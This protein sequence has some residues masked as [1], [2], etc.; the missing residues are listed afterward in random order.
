MEKQLSEKDIAKEHVLAQLAARVEANYHAL[1]EGM[2]NVEEVDL[3][4]AQA[5]VQCVG[6]RQRLS[7]AAGGIRDPLLRILH[8]RTRRENLQRVAQVV[9][10]A[11][12]RARVRGCMYGC[13]YGGSDRPGLPVPSFFLNQISLKSTT[14][15]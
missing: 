10:G 12:V 14:A 9:K 8:K 13:V 11:C 6:T 3:D 7:V 5:G 1:I 15:R 4:L 2:R